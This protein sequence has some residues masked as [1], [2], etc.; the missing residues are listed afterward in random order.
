MLVVRNIL[1][2]LIC[3]SSLSLIWD[4]LLL[5]GCVAGVAAIVLVLTARNLRPGETEFVMSVIPLPL[6]VAAIPAISIAIQSLPLG[7]LS[8]PIWKSTAVALHRP[9]EGS[10]SIDPAASLITLGFY[11]CLIAIAF[12]SA[13]VAVDRQRA[14]TLLFALVIASVISSLIVIVQYFSWLNAWRVFSARAVD[15]VS[16]GAIIAA[17]NFID[18]IE[19]QARRAGTRAGWWI[20]R[21]LPSVAALAICSVAFALSANWAIAFAT[22]YGLF[23]LLSHWIIRRLALGLW[24]VGG[25]AAGALGIAAILVAAYPAHREVSVQLAYAR[26]SQPS[27]L[28]FNQRMLDNSPFVGTGAGTFAALAPIY[29]QFND[30]PSVQTAATTATQLTIELGKPA[31]GL[32]VVATVVLLIVL[33]RASLR[34]GRDSGYSAMGGS[35]LLTLLLL[36]FMDASALATA[37]GLLVAAVLGVAFAQSKSRIG[38]T[39]EMLKAVAVAVADVAH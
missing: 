35:C 33:L 12:V 31:F 14:E 28:A 2:A 5:T 38:R 34:R 27:V 21:M 10:I 16:L 30:A 7:I 24:G 3:A 4:G 11:L 23:A 25:F 1:A 22:A 9:I 17:T 37:T 19:R 20:R 29:R 8:H 32:I 26:E 18:V 13:A 6:L 36:A 15:C 39:T